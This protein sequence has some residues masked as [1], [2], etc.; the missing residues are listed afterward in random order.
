MTEKKTVVYDLR[1]S[2]NGPLSIP[3]FYKE[4]QDW[5]REKDMEVEYKKHMDHRNPKARDIE[6]VV[7]IFKNVTQDIDEVIRLRA[8]FHNVKEVELESDGKKIPTNQVELLCVLDGFVEAHLSTRWD[9]LNP[10]Y[11]FVRT[12]VDKYI[13]PAFN[14]SEKYFG[15]VGGDTHDLHKRLRAFF[16]VYKSK[17]N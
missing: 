1:I 6:W 8:I 2:Y 17:F 3:D 7:E 9:Q 5:A 15:L 4:V 11:Y 14:P 12:L 13:W 10:L 16:N